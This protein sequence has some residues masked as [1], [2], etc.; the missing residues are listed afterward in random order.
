MTASQMIYLYQI[1]R[2]KMIKQHLEPL[3]YRR[4]IS[5]LSDLGF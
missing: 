3:T 1:H 4:F 2:A 5:I